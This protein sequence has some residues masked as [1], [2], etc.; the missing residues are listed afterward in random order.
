MNRSHALVHVA[1][2]AGYLVPSSDSAK[3]NNAVSAASTVGSGVD[4]LECLGHGFAVFVGHE[5][6]SGPDQVHNTGLDGGLG[7]GR[8][9]RVTEPGEPVT[10]HDE[11]VTH[12]PVAELAQTPAQNLAPSVAWT[13]IPRTCFTPSVSTP[14][15]M[16]AALLRTW[17][18]S[19][20]LT[21]R[22][23]R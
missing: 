16:W 1:A 13:Q 23:S 12:A 17:W 15:A 14:T 10:A 6:H 7:P 4:R 20:T 21:T 5:P 11:H 9:D 2:A 3:A 8:F 22:A 18:L 19:R